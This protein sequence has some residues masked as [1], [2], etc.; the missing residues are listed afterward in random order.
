MGAVNTLTFKPGELT[1]F[2]TDGR[3]L[4]RAIA[5]DFGV[6]LGSLRAL[7]IGAGGGAGRAIALQCALE[8]CPEITLVNRTREK[9]D[10]VALEIRGCVE[11]TKGRSVVHVL[12]GDDPRLQF[13]VEAVDLI[14]QCSSLG[15]KEGDASP[16]PLTHLRAEH[17]VYDTIYSRETQLVKDARALGAST[18][19]GLSMLL[20]QGAL[21]FE[22][23]FERPAPID[24]MRS[25]LL[26]YRATPS[27]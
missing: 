19:N 17:L 20:H 27:H 10:S 12:G 11:A 18:S 6:Q 23:W 15:M 1:G 7:I 25:A 14:I 24:E 3:G 13:H 8:G 5:D 26:H 16:I 4:V 21:A 2:N 22:I 9:A